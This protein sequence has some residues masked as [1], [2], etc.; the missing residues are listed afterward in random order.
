MNIDSIT[1]GVVIDHIQ[2]GNAMKLYELLNLKELNVP[3]AMITNAS[4]R[5]MGRKD[6]IKIDANVPVN[7]DLIGFVDPEATINVI[8]D[9]QLVE[10]KKII[11]PEKLVNIVRCRNPRCITCTEQELDQVFVLADKKKKIYR[12]MYCETQA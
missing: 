5:K 2:A 8:R 9:S 10:K 3:V 7:L 4:S 12:C 6:I 11:M 1:N